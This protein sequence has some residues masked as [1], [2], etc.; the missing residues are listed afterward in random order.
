MFNLKPHNQSF[1]ILLLGTLLSIW[2]AFNLLGKYDSEQKVALD[3]VQNKSIL[4]HDNWPS[5]NIKES[6]TFKYPQDWEVTSSE[7]AGDF[8]VTQIK[9]PVKGEI[10][11][12]SS[13]KAF[14]AL[15]GLYTEPLKIGGVD[16]VKVADTL[17]AV[18][19]QDVYYT[20]DLGV[21]TELTAEFESFLDSIELK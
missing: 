15:E 21:N 8:E 9:N 7:T 17:A 1:I 3:K 6:L 2:V 14:F 11:I 20:F 13:T 12:Y 19:H 5:G 16:G 4:S 18:K 10:K